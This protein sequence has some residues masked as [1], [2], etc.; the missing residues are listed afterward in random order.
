M[1]R[2]YCA[3]EAAYARGAAGARAAPG[4]RC[5]TT[6]AHHE[7]KPGPV[8]K[9]MRAAFVALTPT[10]MKKRM[11][12]RLHRNLSEVERMEKEA[13]WLRLHGSPL[14]VLGL[15]EHADLDDVKARYKDLLFETHPDTAVAAAR[16]AGIRDPTALTAGTGGASKQLVASDGM[17]DDE[18]RR[19]AVTKFELLVA[20][21]KMATNP[22][23]VW[24]QG[25]AAPQIYEQLEAPSFV[26]R[27][28]NPTTTFAFIAYGI[29]FVAF[30]VFAYQIAPQAWALM[31]ELAFPDFHRFMVQQEKEEARLRALGIEPDTDPDR[32]ASARV[33]QLKAPGRIIVV[34]GVDDP[35]WQPK[36]KRGKD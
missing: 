10:E 8:A 17:T 28:V 20:A 27:V 32:L 14:R 19:Q 18:V 35:N 29:A 12:G 16:K 4:R 13:Q 3:A 7:Y 6:G 33:M 22:V 26:C 21:H 24:H 30:L 1:L 9:A 5:E 34:D 31:L 15:P 36:N 25:G 2:R 23:S 11:A